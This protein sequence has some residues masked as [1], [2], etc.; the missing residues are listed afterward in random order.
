MSSRDD[1]LEQIESIQNLYDDGIM[2]EEQFETAKSKLMQKLEE[3]ENEE[4]AS[5][6]NKHNDDEE[7]YAGGEDGDDDPY[8]A[9]DAGL[10]ESAAVVGEDGVVESYL[11]THERLLATMKNT[12]ANDQSRWGKSG[13]IYVSISSCPHLFNKV[14]TLG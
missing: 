1:I 2:D 11:D 8:A 13:Q 6:N 7:A 3:L 14:I 12:K 4:S 5:S 9:Y 10:D